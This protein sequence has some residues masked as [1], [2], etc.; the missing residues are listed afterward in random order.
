MWKTWHLHTHIVKRTYLIVYIFY[1][2]VCTCV[3]TS[4]SRFLCVSCVYL[5]YRN[6]PEI[7]LYQTAYCNLIINNKIFLYISRNINTYAIY[8]LLGISVFL[9]R[10]IY[11]STQCIFCVQTIMCFLFIWILYILKK[12]LE[13]FFFN[14]ILV[15]SC[16]LTKSPSG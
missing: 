9:S 7:F 5:N 6:Q 10:L 11:V 2:Y 13:I 12:N 8:K 4:F 1:M 3:L 15:N 14:H 16:I